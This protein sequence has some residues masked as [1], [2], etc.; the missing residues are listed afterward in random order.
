MQNYCVATCKSYWA[1]SSL[2]GGGGADKLVDIVA[3]G[4]S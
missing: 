4:E 2:I 3:G 1:E